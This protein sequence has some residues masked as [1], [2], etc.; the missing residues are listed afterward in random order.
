MSAEPET[1]KRDPFKNSVIVM[2]TLVSVF[3][4]LVTFLQ[5]YASLSASDLAQRSSFNAVNAT[6]LDASRV[7]AASGTIRARRMMFLM[8]VRRSGNVMACE[9]L[10]SIHLDEHRAI[11]D[12]SWVGL[13]RDHARRRN[14]LAGLDAELPI[15]K[16]ALD[17]ISL[18]V[19]L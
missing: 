15:V 16:V 2:L 8:G 17:H 1:E 7:A 10:G 12:L 9:G 4:A 6:G 3:A 18:D 11:L 5:N 14:H 19:A 13:H